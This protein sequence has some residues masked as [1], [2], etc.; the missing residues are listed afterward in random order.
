VQRH[1]AAAEEVPIAEGIGGHG[2]GDAVLL[3]DIFRGV[4]DDPLGH[5]ASWEDGVRAVVVGLAGNRSL[6]T[7]AVVSIADLDLG[8]AAASLVDRG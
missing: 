4:G 5:T 2:G 7:G 8:A 6:E 3:R 1:F